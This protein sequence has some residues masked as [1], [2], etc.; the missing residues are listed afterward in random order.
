M[1]PKSKNVKK[2]WRLYYRNGVVILASLCVGRTTSL[3]YLVPK[4]YFIL[5]WYLQIIKRVPIPEFLYL[6]PFLSQ[7][8]GTDFCRY[9]TQEYGRYGGNKGSL[10]TFDFVEPT[11]E[12]IVWFRAFLCKKQD[13]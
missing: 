12:T 1:A 5:G 4:I 9:Y 8:A 10:V 2:P 11:M 6:I 3:C 13:F 7:T